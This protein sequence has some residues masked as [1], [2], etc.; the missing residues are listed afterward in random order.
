MPRRI[1]TALATTLLLAGI[2]IAATGGSASAATITVTSGADSGAG[3]LRAAIASASDG[4]IIQ[5]DP[6]VTTVELTTAEIEITQS[7]SIEGPGADVLTVRRSSAGGT[8]DF[9]LFRINAPS[10][11]VS[12]SGM[13]LTN[14]KQGA[15]GALNISTASSVTLTEMAF[16]G[17]EGAWAGALW[18]DTANLLVDRSTFS[19]NTSGIGGNCG[20]C[21]GGAVIINTGNATFA[22]STLSNNHATDNGGAIKNTAALTLIN[23]TIA[24]NT[25]GGFGGGLASYVFQSPSLTMKNT[26]FAGNT[27]VVRPDQ[28]DNNAAVPLLVNLNNFIEDGSCNYVRL[29]ASGSQTSPTGF[30]Q[31]IAGLSALASNGGATQTNALSPTSGAAGAGD[32]ATCAGS[33]I[34]GIDQ[35]GVSRPSSCA[36]GAFEPPSAQSTPPTTSPGTSVNDPDS[37]QATDT[38]IPAFT[39]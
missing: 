2:M 38:V 17:N 1:A 31:G 14:G 26:L 6:S 9:R 7:I 25:A 35:R 33:P 13:E 28:C 27:S 16:V 3:S 21:N 10:K 11:S 19:G 15:G 34:S 20:Y 37:G 39:G 32:P 8:P 36:I 5:F 30:L 22:N 24:N 29:V 23:T 12:M 18:L 4:D